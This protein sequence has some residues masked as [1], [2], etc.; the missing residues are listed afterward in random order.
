MP[1]YKDVDVIIQEIDKLQVEL[2]SND[3][4]VWKRN[5]PKYKALA[6]ARAIIDDTLVADVAPRGEVARE[7]LAEVREAFE[8]YGE[9]YGMREKLAE[10]EQRFGLIDCKPCRHFVGCE[11]C[12]TGKVCGDYD[13]GKRRAE[14]AAHGFAPLE[15]ITE[16]EAALEWLDTNGIHAEAAG[17]YIALDHAIATIEALARVPNV[18]EERDGI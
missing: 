12:R 8:R 15:V 2:G 1:Q 18:K 10:L 7:I 13:A 3:D 11:S 9:R 6:L 4:A 5:K 16:L 17:V 14:K